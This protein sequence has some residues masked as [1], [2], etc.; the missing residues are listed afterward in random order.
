[1]TT[2]FAADA[3][4]LQP[5]DPSTRRIARDVSI[6]DYVWAASPHIFRNYVLSQTT[7]CLRGASNSHVCRPSENRPQFS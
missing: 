4:R 1:M 5:T 2:P 6:N 3:A 7:P